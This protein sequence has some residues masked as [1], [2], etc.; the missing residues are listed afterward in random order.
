MD[1]IALAV[2]IVLV[3]VNFLGVFLLVVLREKSAR[4]KQK[5]HFAFEVQEVRIFRDLREIAGFLSFFTVALGTIA[6]FFNREYF[7]GVLISFVFIATII[8]SIAYTVNKI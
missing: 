7:F 5:L 3:V 2:F 8:I 4:D 1:F 6:L